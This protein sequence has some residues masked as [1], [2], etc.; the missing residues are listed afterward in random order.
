M[1]KRLLMI[2]A[3]LLIGIAILLPAGCQKEAPADYF[4]L[5]VGSYWEYLTL[6]VFPSG[7]T[8]VTKDIRMV[9]GKE[10]VDDL[11]CYKIE[12]F[13]IKGNA[14]SVC[15][16]QEF[17]AKTADGVTVEKRSFPL[18]KNLMIDWELRNKPGETR[19]KTN[20]KDGDTWKW[21][22]MVTQRIEEEKKD[23]QAP[24]K[25][26]PL[27]GTVEYEYKG[28]E[29]ITVMNKEMECILI[30]MHEVSE[31]KQEFELYAW[32][33]PNIGKVREEQ[34][35][36]KGSDVVKFV[37]VLQNYNIANKDLFKK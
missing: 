19:F 4:P 10:L 16:Y 37:S 25:V 33:A 9:T 24:P 21:E 26:K 17:M 15:Q 30:Y 27:K 23:Q 31:D 6:S 35:L 28:R 11:E 29:T 5:G 1:S 36:Y 3:V 14:P 22:G 20:L 18:L 7:L 32:Y 13:S 8:D 2:V 12:N 34:T